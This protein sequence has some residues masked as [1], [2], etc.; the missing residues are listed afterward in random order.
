MNYMENIFFFC[1][2]KNNIL[3]ETIYTLRSSIVMSKIEEAYCVEYEDIID[4]EQAYELYWDGIISDAK[5]FQCADPNCNAQITCRNMTKERKLMKQIPHFVCYGEHDELC[6]YIRD[7]KVDYSRKQKQKSK[8]RKKYLNEEVDILSFNRPKKDSVISK[9]QKDINLREVKKRKEELNGKYKHQTK[10]IPTYYSI[11][12]IV[13]KYIKYQ[14]CGELDAHYVQINGYDVS[15]NH[16]FIN[17]AYHSVLDV[18][19][20]YSRVYYGKGKIKK[21][22][23]KEDFVIIFDEG[24]N[25]E[26][27]STAIYISNEVIAQ[28][29]CKLKI[30]QMLDMLVHMPNQRAMFY[31]YT[32]PY[33][34]EDKQRINLWLRSMDYFDYRIISNDDKA[35]S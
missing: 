21:I 4:P 1:R 18:T 17:M 24:F 32:K 13:S 9:T 16:M 14:E 19:G 8:S 15:Y 12:S 20:K 2:I 23:N 11:K 6:N 10:R 26:G 31:I 33:K 29:Y 28:H 7:F 30:K 35:E 5:G 22:K 3:K 25:D 27:Y 34:N